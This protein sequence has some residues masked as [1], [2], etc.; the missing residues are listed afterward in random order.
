MPVSVPASIYQFH[1]YYHITVILFLN[2]KHKLRAGGRGA[3]ANSRRK[4]KLEFR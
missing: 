4:V 3:I 2:E 1:S